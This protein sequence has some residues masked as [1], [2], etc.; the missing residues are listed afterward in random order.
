[1]YILLRLKELTM[2]KVKEVP[3][4]EVLYSFDIFFKIFLTLTEKNY[5]LCDKFMN[6][7]ISPLCLAFE[8]FSGLLNLF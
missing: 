2:L 5:L 8:S 4:F 7:S 1:M 3:I 6:K